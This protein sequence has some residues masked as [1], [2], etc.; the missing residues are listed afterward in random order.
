MSMHQ[1]RGTSSWRCYTNNIESK[2]KKE[3]RKC[4]LSEISW[5]L[6][7]VTPSSLFLVFERIDF[8]GHEEH[9]NVTRANKFDCIFSST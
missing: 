7:R 8:P 9:N 5:Q 3:D 1:Y 6:Y 4:L 2:M